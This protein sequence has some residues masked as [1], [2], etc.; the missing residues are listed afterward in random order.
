MSDKKYTSIQRENAAGRVDF[1]G[2][3]A[4]WEWSQDQNDSTSILIKM[5]DNPELEL[6]VTQRTPVMSNKPPSAKAGPAANDAKSQK[7]AFE[8]AA[9][10]DT[11]A[12]LKKL[13]GAGGFDP[14]NRG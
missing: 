12:Q 2:G 9:E 14:Y 4:V 5:L 3:K 11:L 10:D 13:R 8:Q 1:K 7:A 6:E